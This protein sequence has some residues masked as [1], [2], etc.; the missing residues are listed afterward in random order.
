MFFFFYW[1]GDHRYLQV[2]THSFPTRRSSDLEVAGGGRGLAAGAPHG[3]GDGGETGFV[4]PGMQQHAQAGSRHPAAE[5]G[6]AAAGGTGDEQAEGG[7]FE[8]RR[9]SRPPRSEEHT[10]EL[11]SLMLNSYAVF[12][13]KQQNCTL[14]S[15]FL[16]SITLLL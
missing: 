10:S 15:T 9:I 11:K 1:Y 8:H 13:C 3:I 7:C 16:T 6:A 4:A 12:C 14:S 5:G 2:L